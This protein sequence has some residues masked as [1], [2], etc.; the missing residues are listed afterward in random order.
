MPVRQLKEEIYGTETFHKGDLADH[1]AAAG[2][3]Q[4]GGC[5]DREPGN[6]Y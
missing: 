4:P 3:G 5:P 2:G 6:Y 1:G